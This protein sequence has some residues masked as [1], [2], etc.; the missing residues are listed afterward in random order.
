[1]INGSYNFDSQSDPSLSSSC[2]LT[3][4]PSSTTRITV[5]DHCASCNCTYPSIPGPRFFPSGSIWIVIFANC[6]GRPRRG[7]NVAPPS[8]RCWPSNQNLWTIAP[9]HG[10]TWKKGE[11]DNNMKQRSKQLN[12]KWTNHWTHN[13]TNSGTNRGNSPVSLYPSL[14]VSTRLYPSLPCE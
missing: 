1:M 9:E 2:T 7:W 5:Q 12:I 11:K 13:G 8:L 3:N 4:T 10:W 14:P 6:L